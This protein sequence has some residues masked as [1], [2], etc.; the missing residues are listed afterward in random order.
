MMNASARVVAAVTLGFAP[1][2]LVA[3]ALDF[4][5]YDPVDGPVGP[6]GPPPI[7]VDAALYE[8]RAEAGRDAAPA[9]ASATDQQA[10][11]PC[12]PPASCFQQASTCGMAC[13]QTYAACARRCGD[14]DVMCIQVCTNTRQGCL[15]RCAS[16]CIGCTQDAGCTA[17][18][19]CL[20]ATSS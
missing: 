4:G 5:R 14:A 12:S 17:A 1:A 20:D 13:R 18:N 10:T 11:G 2:P 6:M 16:S 9:D 3:C 8:D 7:I 15:G 19:T